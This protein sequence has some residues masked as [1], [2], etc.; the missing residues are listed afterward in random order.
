LAEIAHEIR[1]VR[2]ESEIGNFEWEGRMGGWRRRVKR[3]KELA[4]F[5][6]L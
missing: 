1:K 3:R 4:I 2:K 6:F 5:Y